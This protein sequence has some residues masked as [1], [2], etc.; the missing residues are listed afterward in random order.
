MGCS[1]ILTGGINTNMCAAL[2]HVLSDLL[3][4][5]T[6]LVRYSASNILILNPTQLSLSMSLTVVTLAP[7]LTL[8]MMTCK[9]EAIIIIEVSDRGGNICSTQADGIATLVVCSIIVVGAT[10][11]LLTWFR[12]VY[13][14]I[15]MPGEVSFSPF[16]LFPPPV[17]QATNCLY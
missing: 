1:S 3:R 8:Q 9:V 12:E 6:T 10:G 13:I 2:L 4:S 16:Y 5:S 15:T 17:E 7:L 11:A 14:Y